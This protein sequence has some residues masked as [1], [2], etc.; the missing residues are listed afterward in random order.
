MSEKKYDN[1]NRGVL[2]ENN[3]KTTPNAPDFLGSVDVNGTEYWLSAWQKYSDAK[4]D[5]LSVTVRTKDED[6]RPKQKT[7]EYPSDKP[8]IFARRRERDKAAEKN[9]Y[10]DSQG[11]MPDND[12]PF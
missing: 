5:Y 9:L 6:R 4:G 8:S 12:I 3:K 10:D 1:T 11:E 2:F 7:E